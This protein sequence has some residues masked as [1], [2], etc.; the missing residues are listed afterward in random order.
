MRLVSR[1]SLGCSSTIVATSTSTLVALLAAV[2]LSTALG[3]SAHTIGQANGIARLPGVL[4]GSTGALFWL[5]STPAS[6]SASSPQVAAVAQ[7]HFRIGHPAV[8]AAGAGGAKTRH[9]STMASSVQLPTQT[10]SFAGFE[11]TPMLTPSASTATLIRDAMDLFGAKP[12]PGIF[13]RWSP[14]AVFADPI[15]HA[16]GSRQFLAQ[17]YGMPAAFSESQTLQWKLLKDEPRLIEYVQKQRYK[18]KGLGAVKEMVS[19][20]VMERDEAGKVVRFED[21]WNHKP[22]GGA[23][24]WPFRRLNALTLPWLVGVPGDTKQAVG[25]D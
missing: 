21:R 20:V 15:C 13:E 7:R 24:G 11:A 4:A 3:T 18:V 22:L 1:R 2:S 9:A 8:A 12:S 19:T 25:K 14:H 16:E 5:S 17:W 23:L 10:E 6:V